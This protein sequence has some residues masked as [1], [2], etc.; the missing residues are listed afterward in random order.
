MTTVTLAVSELGCEGCEEIVE[1]ALADTGGVTEATADHE[2]GTVVVEGESYS[3]DDLVETVEFAGY[4]ATIS[5][6]GDEEE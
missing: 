4:E 5:E 6:R 2:S 1:G 3:E